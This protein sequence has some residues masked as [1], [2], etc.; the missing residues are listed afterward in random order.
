[1]KKIILI[2]MIVVFALSFTIS[3][4]AQ[5]Q[6][7]EGIVTS[8]SVSL[9]NPLGTG[10]AAKSPQALIG[11]V[12]QSALGVVGSIALVMFIFGGFVWMTAAGNE[13]K[14]GKGKDILTW[15]TLGLVVIFASYALVKFVISGLTSTV[16]G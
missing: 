13:Q 11:K 2:L 3:A 9:Q 16:G 12:I 15:A 14:V 6:G 4:N 8:G 7:S 1:M 10:E 5:G